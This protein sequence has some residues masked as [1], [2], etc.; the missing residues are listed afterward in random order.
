MT[1]CGG[2]I[3]ELESAVATAQASVVA[4]QAHSDGLTAAARSHSEELRRA[5]AGVEEMRD[6]CK[7]AEERATAAQNALAEAVQAAAGQWALGRDCWAMMSHGVCAR[8][9]RPGVGEG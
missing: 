8:R 3:A 1:V 2:Q 4:A 6:R 5:Q 7:Q 9:P